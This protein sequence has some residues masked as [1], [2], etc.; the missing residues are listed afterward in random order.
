MSVLKPH[1]EWSDFCSAIQVFYTTTKLRLLR[2]R[3]CKF[4]IWLTCAYTS[5]QVKSSMCRVNTKPRVWLFREACK[6]TLYRYFFKKLSMNPATSR[7]INVLSCYHIYASLFSNNSKR[8]QSLQSNTVLT[9]GL[10]ICQAIA[11]VSTF[12]IVGHCMQ[13]KYSL[14]SVNVYQR[15]SWY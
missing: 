1:E 12:Q 7:K 13:F 9:T 4:D 8:A 6:I 15:S 11:V 2:F 14:F 5:G 3:F 10:R